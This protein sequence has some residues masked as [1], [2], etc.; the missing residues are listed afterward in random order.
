MIFKDATIS[1]ILGRK[2]V[3]RGTCL[4]NFCTQKYQFFN[5]YLL[6]K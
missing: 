1:E 5:F 4:D 6:K 3:E 2:N